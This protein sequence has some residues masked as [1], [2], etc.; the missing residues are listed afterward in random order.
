M[1]ATGDWGWKGGSLRERR[2][3]WELGEMPTSAGVPAASR[4]C[5]PILVARCCNSSLTFSLAHSHWWALSLSKRL[6]G[7]QEAS[8]TCSS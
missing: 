8:S 3:G 7:S 5:W 4:A 2:V 1:E 6:W